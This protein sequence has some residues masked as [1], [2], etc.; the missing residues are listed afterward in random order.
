MVVSMVSTAVSGRRF[1]PISSRIRVSSVTAIR[2][3][4]VSLS[5]VIT[6]KYAKIM[7]FF[8]ILDL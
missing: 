3:R 4:F 7:V 6:E 1:E 2:S 5:V 8:M